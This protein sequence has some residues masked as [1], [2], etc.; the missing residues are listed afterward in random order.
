MSAPNGIAPQLPAHLGRSAPSRGPKAGRRGLGCRETSMGWPMDD[1]KS[2]HAAEIG[3]L[4]EAGVAGSISD[5]PI[6][7]DCC[8]MRR[9]FP[10][11]R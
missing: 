8:G 10:L 3:A 11:Y 4:A 7:N 6:G 1:T 2:W 9:T 5:L